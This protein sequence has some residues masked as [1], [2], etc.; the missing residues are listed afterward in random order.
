MIP[1]LVRQV[2]HG[3]LGLLQ[4][5]IDDHRDHLHPIH[6]CLMDLCYIHRYFSQS[7]PLCCC[8]DCFGCYDCDHQEVVENVLM[9]IGHCIGYLLLI[10]HLWVAV[11]VLPICSCEKIA[12]IGQNCW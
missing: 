6:S 9:M 2:G 1:L 10:L 4:E 11:E 8:G 5:H 3:R 7:R 12:L